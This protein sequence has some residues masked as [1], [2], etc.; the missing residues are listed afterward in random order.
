MKEITIQELVSADHEQLQVWLTNR[1]YRF[2][3]TNLMA[4]TRE[5][6]KHILFPTGGADLD[7]DD[8]T[9]QAGSWVHSPTIV[10]VSIIRLV[11]L[12][13]DNKP[14]TI[15]QLGEFDHPKYIEEIYLILM[16]YLEKVNRYWQQNSI[17]LLP[18]ADMKEIR[19]DLVKL[20]DFAKLIHGNAK[21][22]AKIRLSRDQDNAFN[23]QS[24]ALRAF[25]EDTDN[26]LL[27]INFLTDA[28]HYHENKPERDN[29]M[30]TKTDGFASPVVSPVLDINYDAAAQFKNRT[31][32][33]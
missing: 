13:Y 11:E 8:F 23:M 17:A 20:V 15:Y 25:K 27:D 29:I 7:E 2:H 33:W 4:N 31:K 30:N 26:E 5:E 16:Q 28:M 32:R 6:R 14:D 9:A 19:T 3:T 10:H 1:K 21:F 22:Q 18:E 12:S 24:A